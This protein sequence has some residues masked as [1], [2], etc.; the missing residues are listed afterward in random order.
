MTTAVKD[1]LVRGKE[2]KTTLLGLNS[3]HGNFKYTDLLHAIEDGFE[4]SIFE[5]FRI[6]I[7]AFD[8]RINQHGIYGW[9]PLAWAAALGHVKVVKWL[10]QNNA[11]LLPIDWARGNKNHETV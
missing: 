10:L 2:I 3:N 7:R 6:G 8:E 1:N 9:C 4:G 5:L 11:D